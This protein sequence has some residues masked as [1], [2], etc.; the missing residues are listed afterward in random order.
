MQVLA[1]GNDALRAGREVGGTNDVT[2]VNVVDPL[3]HVD[4]KPLPFVRLS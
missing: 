2:R 4:T 3:T 1:A